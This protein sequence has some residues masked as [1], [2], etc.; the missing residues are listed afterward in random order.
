MQYG[1]FIGEG[2]AVGMRE[3]LPMVTSAAGSL[4]GAATDRGSILNGLSVNGGSGGGAPI[5]YNQYITIS[6]SNLTQNDVKKAMQISMAD[7][8][9]MMDRYQK[10][11]GRVAFA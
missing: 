5:T 11:R 1:S 3:A 9:K 10:K 6:G 8:E 2:L 4:A 7:F